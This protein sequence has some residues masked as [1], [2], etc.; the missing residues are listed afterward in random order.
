MRRLGEMSFVT[1]P[2]WNDDNKVI[3]VVEPNLYGCSVVRVADRP[4]EG[5]EA[6]DTAVLALELDGQYEEIP[7][8][9][10]V[11]AAVEK[12]IGLEKQM[13]DLS[14]SCRD[15]SGKAEL[16]RL[17][18]EWDDTADYATP[19]E[20]EISGRM[21]ES[22]DRLSSRIAGYTHNREE[23]EKLIEQAKKLSGSTEWKKTSAAMKDLMAQWKTLG[24]AGDDCND[25]LWDSFRKARQVFYDAQD[26]HFK[27]MDAKHA[28]AKEAKTQIIA[29]AQ[30][31]MANVQNW[32]QT[33]EKF[34][35][36]MDRWKLAGSAG[37]EDDDALWAQF[38]E[39]R[40]SYYAG[41]K[42]FVKGQEAQWNAAA[43]KKRALIEEAKAVSDQHDTSQENTERMKALVTEWKQ[44]GFAGRE[45]DDA[46]WNEF[47]AAKDVFWNE[48]H[49]QYDAKHSEWLSRRQDIVDRKKDRIANL[50]EQ[51]RKLHERVEE[52]SNIGQITKLNGYIDEN[53]AEIKKIQE[54]IRDIEKKN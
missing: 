36:L 40:G 44:A 20:K 41:R 38:N 28:E 39:L 49:A 21:Q 47:C 29:E 8:I 27:E 12:K 15:T 2:E 46:L 4:A 53:N 10:E 24:N 13:H 25:A 50:Q 23:K 7:S 54:G 34:S 5:Q 19:K 42:K 3:T 35:L 1:M 30:E 16:D 48:K 18:A 43:E 22:V 17:K 26:A 9:D 51:N 11:T 33:G 37:R 45:Q 32:K 14:R 52:S 6:G 31:L